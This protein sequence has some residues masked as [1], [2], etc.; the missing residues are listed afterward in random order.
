MQNSN[1]SQNDINIFYQFAFK[2]IEEIDAGAGPLTLFHHQEVN[3]ALDV[4]HNEVSRICAK[5][6]S[7]LTQ[8]QVYSEES[9]NQL[10]NT[11][12]HL[13]RKLALNKSFSYLYDIW[14]CDI[15]KGFMNE[16]KI[17]AACLGQD[18][19]YTHILH[20]VG[21]VV[22]H[23][24]YSQNI[25]TYTAEYEQAIQRESIQRENTGVFVDFRDSQQ[26]SQM[27]M[28]Q[29]VQDQQNQ[30]DTQDINVIG[31]RVN[32]Q[33]INNNT[34]DNMEHENVLIHEFRTYPSN[35]NTIEICHYD[36]NEQENSSE[37]ILAETMESIIN[38]NTSPGL[39]DIISNF[40]YA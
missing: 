30:Q 28:R 26:I 36:I 37:M 8:G 12:M 31:L 17:L 32:S 15:Q 3:D 29:V 40:D 34:D 14:Y 38:Q 21:S 5:S 1:Q 23:F 2:I 22:Y 18:R 33:Q 10:Q 20:S 24:I 16:S 11:V 7:T 39:L 9:S 25:N 19:S 35:I 4:L 27:L 13:V 6:N